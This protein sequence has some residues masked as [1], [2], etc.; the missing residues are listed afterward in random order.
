M[1]SSQDLREEP[2]DMKM[3]Q[4]FS[5]SVRVTQERDLWTFVLDVHTVPGFSV[6]MLILRF[7]NITPYLHN[8]DL[9]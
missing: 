6:G 2:W 3:L 8:T 5:P 4:S 9:L 1:I 7:T